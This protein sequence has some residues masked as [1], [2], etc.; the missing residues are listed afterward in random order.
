MTGFANRRSIF[1]VMVVAL[2]V[3]L[4]STSSY[5]LGTD[6][7]RMAC[8]PDVFR[9]CSADIPNVDRIVACLRSQKQNL[10]A[11]CAAVFSTSATRSLGDIDWCLFGKDVGRGQE[12]WLRWCGPAVH[13]Q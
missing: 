8:T 10:S 6:E 4:P 9:L 3:S 7:Q 13:R 5:A 1:N 11:G 2:T 12:D